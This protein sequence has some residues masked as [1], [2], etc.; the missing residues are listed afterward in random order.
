MAG[1]NSPIGR[2]CHRKK[3]D[4]SVAR[5]LPLGGSGTEHYVGHSWIGFADV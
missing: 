3:V 5:S 4:V 1:G 2:Y